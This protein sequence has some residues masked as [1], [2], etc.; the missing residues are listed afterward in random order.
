MSETDEDRALRLVRQI[1][2][3]VIERTRV[4]EDD[5]WMLAAEFTQV[6]VDERVKLE[7]ARIG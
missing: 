4:L 7:K 2:R 5:A 6:R 1:R 3:N